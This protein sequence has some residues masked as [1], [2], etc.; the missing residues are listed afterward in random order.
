MKIAS[1]ILAL[2]VA[3]PVAAQQ[4]PIVPST[5]ANDPAALPGAPTTPSKP[6]PP[7]TTPK[8]S[9]PFPTRKPILRKKATPKKSASKPVENTPAPA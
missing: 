7:E 4:Q 1:L 3:L 9:A 2:V 8:S 6:M 5:P